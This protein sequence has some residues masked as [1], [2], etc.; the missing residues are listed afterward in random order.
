MKGVLQ[1]ETAANAKHLRQGDGCRAELG[2]PGV[3]E[4]RGLGPGPPSGPRVPPG[5]AG[6]GRW[7]GGRG[8]GHQNRA[9]GVV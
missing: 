9:V 4:R 5:G 2:E 1:Q 3:P 7:G 8:R 6:G